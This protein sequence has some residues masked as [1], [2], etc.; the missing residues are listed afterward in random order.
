MVS[1][2][3]S[4]PPERDIAMEIMIVRAMMTDL[5]PFSTRVD[6]IKA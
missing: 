4:P 2:H 5:V 1:H 6:F 3:T